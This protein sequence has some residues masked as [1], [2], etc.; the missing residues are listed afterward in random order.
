MAWCVVAASFRLHFEVG[1]NP[2]ANT[3]RFG[4]GPAT[5]RLFSVCSPLFQYSTI[6]LFQTSTISCRCAS[7]KLLSSSQGFDQLKSLSRAETCLF[8]GFCVGHHRIRRTFRDDLTVSQGDPATGVFSG[9][10]DIMGHQ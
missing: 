4:T 10:L 6:P 1:I 5:Y 2:E 3:S 8:H 9:E 7:T